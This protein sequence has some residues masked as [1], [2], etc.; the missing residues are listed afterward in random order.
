[1]IWISRLLRAAV[2]LAC[3]VV[4]GRIVPI[5]L[6]QIQTGNACPMLGPIPACHVVS[7]SYAA[8]GAAVSIGWRGLKWLFFVGAAPVVGLALAGTSLEL[9][10]IPTCPRSE[11]G[12]PLCYSSLMIGLGLL[13]GFSLSIWIDRKASIFPPDKI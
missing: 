7:I 10:G 1:M 13:A 6:T 5:S 11:T 9:A 2:L 4:L 12:R 8:M 3:L